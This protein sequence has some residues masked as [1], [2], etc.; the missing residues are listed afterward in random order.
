MIVGALVD[1]EYL[2]DE[3]ADGGIDGLGDESRLA[4]YRTCF[5]LLDRFDDDSGD[6]DD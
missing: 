1:L 5:L 2:L 4:I 6:S 3:V